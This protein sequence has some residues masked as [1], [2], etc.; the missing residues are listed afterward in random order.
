M[1]EAQQ[2]KT[3]A[4]EATE[5][6]RQ[7]NEKIAHILEQNQR[8]KELANRTIAKLQKKK[9]ELKYA[10][11]QARKSTKPVKQE[12]LELKDTCKLYKDGETKRRKE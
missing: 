9:H 5:T 11:E 7:A 3:Q 2:A 1:N 12:L 8:D 10:K 6:T 4:N